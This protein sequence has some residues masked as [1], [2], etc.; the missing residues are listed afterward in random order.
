MKI[1]RRRLLVSAAGLSAS[2]A[3]AQGNR[4][5]G[6]QWVFVGTNTGPKSKGIYRFTFDPATGAAAD[7]ILA[8][9]TANP[10]FIAIHPSR[11]FLHAVNAIADYGGQNTGAVSA[12]G[13]DAKTGALTFLNQQPSA[14]PGP[15][16]IS[17]DK[18]GRNAL[19]AN[20]RGGSVAVLPIGPDGKLSPPSA[21]IQHA[22]SSVHKT[23]QEGPHAHSINLDQAERFAFVADLGLDKVLVY[24]F[25][26]A[27]GKIVAHDPPS[28]STAPGAGPRHFSF[29]PNGRFA[30]V[31][32]EL[33][34]T[35]TAFRYDASAGRLE[36]IQAITTVPEGT[37]G[38]NYTAEVRVHP[39]GRFLYGSNR[40][41]DSIAIF[42]ID[43]ATGML[44]ALGHQASGGK[45]PR[46]FT[47]DP[48]GRWMIVGNQ[49]SDNVLI[50]ALDPE[51]GLLK[52]TGTELQCPAPICFRM[53]PVST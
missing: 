48:T 30:Y 20:Y 1:D 8:A 16:H 26:G 45:W 53:L 51:T 33:N 35:V 29:H 32:N 11:R 19:V 23:R 15:C 5:M 14:G 31:I 7:V 42:R 27:A 24:R 36:P 6:K 50:M 13:L 21:A 46:N 3:Y 18:A 22:G 41:H 39:N 38:E 17:I 47:F 37:T 44:T 10:T 49:N 34:S 40:G 28:A 4:R 52:P 12:F 2:A 43:P 25:D 9:E